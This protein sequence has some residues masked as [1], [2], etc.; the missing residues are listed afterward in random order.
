MTRD[1]PT[2]A[3][4]PT[5]EP[6]D[7]LRWEQAVIASSLHHTAKHIALML[8]H[9]AGDAGCLPAGGPQHGEAMATAT[10]HGGRWVRQALTQLEV[11]RLI[12]RPNIQSW[13]ADRGVRP[14]TLTLPLAPRPLYTEDGALRTA[15]AH[16][17][18]AAS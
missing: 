17:A 8:S 4:V 18:P 10:G 13:S 16:P 12:S 15:P 11:Y 2:P 9:Y 5:R 7:R 6:Y 1:T 3:D 14:I